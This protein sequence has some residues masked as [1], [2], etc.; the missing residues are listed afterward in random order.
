[1]IYPIFA[2]SYIGSIHLYIFP[3]NSSVKVEENL[4]IGKY[5]FLRSSRRGSFV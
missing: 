2:A 1:M 4:I 3:N 5:P